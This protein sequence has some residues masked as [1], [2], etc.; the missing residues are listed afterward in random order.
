MIYARK[1]TVR[2]GSELGGLLVA[3]VVTSLA[4]VRLI[5]HVGMFG[6]AITRPHID[7]GGRVAGNLARSAG[8]ERR[9]C[10]SLQ[11]S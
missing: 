7:S 2:A 8:Q 11:K 10:S 5:A 6:A 9:N 4:I 3:G 1:G